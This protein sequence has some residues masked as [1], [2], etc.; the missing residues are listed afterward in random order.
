MKHARGKYIGFM[1]ADDL[2]R[3]HMV[4]RLY[5][6]AEKNDCDIAITSVYQITK[7]G[8][9]PFLQYS[10]KE[11]VAIDGDKFLRM[12]NTTGWEYTVVIWNKLYRASLIKNRP[13]PPLVVGE[14]SSWGPYIL[15]YADRICYINDFS[16]AYDR[17]NPASLANRW[18]KMSQEERFAYYK[19]ICLFYLENGNPER[20]QLLKE[21]AVWDIAK[22]GKAYAYPAYDTLIKQIETDF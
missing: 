17:R 20:I 22:A 5:Q 11:D 9:T 8:Y 7:N 19:N 1:D 4:E 21:Y 18:E 12:L 10:V 16:Y 6:S 3:P 14:D 15:S 2:I 13:I